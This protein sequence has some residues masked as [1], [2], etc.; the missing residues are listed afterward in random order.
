MVQMW[1][2]GWQSRPMC[3]RYRRF[4][5]VRKWTTLRDRITIGSLDGNLRKSSHRHCAFD[6]PSTTC[7]RITSSLRPVYIFSFIP[8]SIVVSFST[9][10]P[11]H[12]NVPRKRSLSGILHQ[13]IFHHH[14]EVRTVSRRQRRCPRCRPAGSR[15]MRCKYL[16]HSYHHISIHNALTQL[17]IAKLLQQHDWH[18]L[19]PV[20]LQHR[21]RRMLLLSP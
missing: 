12:L 5:A 4:S 19:E 1:E 21:R 11:R 17:P 8:S 16:N 14:N 7:L 18:C 15:L 2:T 9:L 10:Q 13:S 20:P 6:Q 3:A